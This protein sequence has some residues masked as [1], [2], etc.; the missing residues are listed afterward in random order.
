M[1]DPPPANHVLAANGAASQRPLHEY[2]APQWGGE[3]A[4]A[5]K[6][7]GMY[8]VDGITMLNAKVDALTTLYSKLGNVNAV[9]TPPVSAI[10]CNFSGGPHEILNVVRQLASAINNRNQE[11]LPN[12]TEVNPREH[13]NAITLRSDKELGETSERKENKEVEKDEVN[14]HE[15]QAKI[16]ERKNESNRKGKVED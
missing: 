8:E 4:A 10:P 6:P 12:K 11:N 5:K 16:D 1:D 9:T 13:V 7:A 15:E 14:E 3:R 2:A